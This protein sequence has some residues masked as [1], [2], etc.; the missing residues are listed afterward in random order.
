MCALVHAQA[1]AA[2][3]AGR[4]KDAAAAF[5]AAAEVEPGADAIN[6]ALHAGLCRTRARLGTSAREAAAESCKAALAIVPDDVDVWV[7]RVRPLCFFARQTSL[8][9]SEDHRCQ[10]SSGPIQACADLISRCLLRQSTGP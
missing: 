1:E 9:S 4:W 2:E 8:E 6:G 3:A 10:H 7:L 5:A